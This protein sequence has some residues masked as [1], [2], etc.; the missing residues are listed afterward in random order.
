[1]EPTKLPQR[2]VNS[3]KWAQVCVEWADEQNLLAWVG[4][5]KELPYST[6]FSGHGCAELGLAMLAGALRKV[7]KGGG[8]SFLPSYEFEISAKARGATVDR[9][10][11]HCCQYVDILR[12]LNESSRK[13]LQELEA[14]CPKVSEDVWTF[15]LK[16]EFVYEQL[17]PRHRNR[18]DVFILDKYMEQVLDPAQVY[19]NMVN[20]LQSVLEPVPLEDVAW[21]EAES[22][23]HELR[24]EMLENCNQNCAL[25]RDKILHMDMSD[26]RVLLSSS[27]QANYRAYLKDLG[28]ADLPKESRPIRAVCVSQDPSFI[29]MGGSPEKLPAFTTDSTRRIMLTSK[30][31]NWEKQHWFPL[32][33]LIAQVCGIGELATDAIARALRDRD[34]LGM[35]KEL[36]F[37]NGHALLP[38]GFNNASTSWNLRVEP[39]NAKKKGHPPEED[40]P[41]K[42]QKTVL[43][44]LNAKYFEEICSGRKRYSSKNRLAPKRI[45]KILEVDREEAVE[46]GAPVGPDWD[47]IFGKDCEK[48]FAI[49]FE[50][51]EKDDIPQD[52][53]LLS[54][55]HATLDHLRTAASEARVKGE[56]KVL[57]QQELNSLFYPKDSRVVKSKAQER[58]EKLREVQFPHNLI[59]RFCE[60]A[61]QH[62]P[63]EYMAWILGNIEKDSKTGKSISY[64][65]GL[66]FPKQE[67][68]K[69]SVGEEGSEAA[70]LVKHLE[71]TNT[72]VIGWV[73]SHLSFQAF[74]SSTD[75][76]MM[77]RIQKDL[78]LA[79]GLV[80]DSEKKVRCMRL[81]NL[82]MTEVEGCPHD[83]QEPHEHPISNEEAV[84]D[85]P[86]FIHYAGKRSRLS[87]FDENLAPRTFSKHL[88]QSFPRIEDC[89][90]GW[91]AKKV[92][93]QNS[94][95]KAG[96]TE[97]PSSDPAIHVERQTNSSSVEANIHF[98]Q[99]L[100]NWLVDSMALCF[101]SPKEAS[102]EFRA[103]L[104][105]LSGENPD[106][107]NI[108]EEL[109]L[110]PEGDVNFVSLGQKLRQWEEQ[111]EAI[112]REL[113]AV[114]STKRPPGRPFGSCK[115]RKT[116]A[117]E[118][119]ADQKDTKKNKKKTRKK[120]TK[121][122]KTEN[123]SEGEESVAV[124]EE[125]PPTDPFG[126]VEEANKVPNKCSMIPLYTKC[127]IVEYAKK[128]AAEGKE[129]SIER[130]VMTHFR[131]YFFSQESNQWKSGLLRKWI[132]T[133]DLEG[134]HR[135]P[136]QDVCKG[137]LPD[138]AI[139][140]LAPARYAAARAFP[141]R[142]WQAC[143]A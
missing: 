75:A 121:K 36:R 33:Q 126:E 48:V 1:M 78:S 114:S 116:T 32:F 96:E 98:L 58:D 53:T 104:A 130:A 34:L 94:W 2:L 102:Q 63:N 137:S 122:K 5:M 73:H 43:L 9:I 84:E 124:E 109:E 70:T 105:E 17:C 127:I 92:D 140:G 26:W 110:N 131:K 111:Q 49:Y 86:F 31:R 90:M 64:A 11:E 6:W 76:H 30:E 85:V 107:S 20:H 135:I 28:Q 106:L 3:F 97:Q 41:A 71:E 24:Q 113:P 118:E 8:D 79:Y 67:S 89:I 143:A 29:N 142:P 93:K 54:K 100:K 136:W 55:S 133:Y 62:A 91:A 132:Q 47:A 141:E 19:S 37:H 95:E 120:D 45:L 50:P 72:L 81:N 10:P 128:V 138:E 18:Y 77:Y 61:W 22:F 108:G 56:E 38:H 139:A 125:A 40:V 82:G 12:M 52:T 7:G 44:P 123:Q 59:K 4:T 119:E 27:E 16:Q 66:Y 60:H 68:D 87:L 46:R 88:D 57:S 103:L 13:S 51:V 14:T 83:C 42:V 112:R 115:K 35:P 65:K 69:W 39:E 101:S 15:L 117:G 80:M 129:R 21:M 23:P 134:H 74:F 25:D 99:N